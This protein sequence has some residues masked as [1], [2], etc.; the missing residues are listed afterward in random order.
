MPDTGDGR[1]SVTAAISWLKTQARWKEVSVHEHG[2]IPGQ[3]IEQV[4]EIC[5]IIVD[6]KLPKNSEIDALPPYGDGVGK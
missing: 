1:E 4:T 6:P 2:G 5:H 3:Q